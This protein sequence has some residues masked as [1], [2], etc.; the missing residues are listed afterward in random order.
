MYDLRYPPT[1]INRH[2]KT[3][4]NRYNRPNHKHNDRD[5][6]RNRSNSNQQM[7]TRPY[8]VFQDYAPETFAPVFDIS[9]GLGVLATGA[10]SSL[11]KRE[12]GGY[13]RW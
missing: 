1:G 3:I 7:S 12:R 8:L 13:D 6:L 11:Y 2:L 10:F 5:L 9:K 4:Y